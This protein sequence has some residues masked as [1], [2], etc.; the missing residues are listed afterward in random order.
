LK[1]PSFTFKIPFTGLLVVH[2]VILPKPIGLEIVALV[3][4]KLGK[5]IYLNGNKLES[6]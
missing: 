1:I 2:F 6:K 3:M 5:G 4:V